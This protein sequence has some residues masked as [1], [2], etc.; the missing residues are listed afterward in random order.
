MAVAQLTMAGIAPALAREVA[1]GPDDARR[2]ARARGATRVLMGL[3][4]AISV[5]YFPLALLGLAPTSGS[6]LYLGWLLSVIYAT[7]FGLKML[8]FALDRSTR[9]AALEFASDAVFF[10]TLAVVVALAP[11]AGILAFCVAYGMFVI[12]ATRT[13]KVSSEGVQPVRPRRELVNYAGWAS[14]ATYA[15][16]GRFT[17]AV[18][19]AG[20]AAGSLV[21]GRLAALLAILMPLFLIPQAAGVLTFADVARAKTDGSA[22]THVR[23][24]CRTAGWVAALTTAIACLFGHEI[25]SLLIGSHDG[26]L[27]L[28]FF[29]LMVAAGPQIVA[30][31]LS[32]AVAAQGAVALNASFSVAAFAVMV[33]SL[34]L[35][36]APLGLLGAAIAIAMSMLVNGCAAIAVARWRFG[37]TMH[38]VAGVVV[39]IGLAC[40]AIALHE[41]PLGVRVTLMLLGLAVGAALA[42]G[43]T[44]PPGETTILAIRNDAAESSAS[45]G[46]L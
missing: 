19:L 32:N 26:Q 37:V 38:D 8:L 33:I 40:T 27:T 41:L 12:R 21:A 30:I 16:I 46:V 20:V 5:V 42:V 18:A 13:F 2:Y 39:G 34:P 23:R 22:A 24:A 6:S 9:Y 28:A 43:A 35:L 11:T 1:R 29:V 36:V 17:I 31:P 10:L 45:R 4:V 3:T 15:S 25:V 14:V 7:Y 44:R